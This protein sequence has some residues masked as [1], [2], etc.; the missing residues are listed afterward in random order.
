MHAPK[1]SAFRRALIR[2]AT[3]SRR[4]FIKL[5]A[6]A[7][8]AGAVVSRGLQRPLL[9]SAPADPVPIPIGSFGFHVNAPAFIDPPDA[10]P[11]TITNFNGFSGL[12]Y[13]SGMVTRTNL[14]THEEDRLPFDSADMRFMLGE[15]QGVDGRMHHGAF[16]F[17]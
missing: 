8:A 6:G 15:Y 13:I 17:I 11:V 4:G 5:G 3:V 7:L 2:P 9:A 10:D 12:A 1:I 16:G 14:V